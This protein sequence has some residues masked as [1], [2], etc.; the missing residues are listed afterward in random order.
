MDKDGLYVN[1]YYAGLG[2]PKKYANMREPLFISWE[3]FEVLKFE[4]LRGTPKEAPVKEK[5]PDS[6]DAPS[7]DY[8]DKLPIVTL[9][10]IKF[11][12]DMDRKERRPVSNPRHVFNFEKQASE[13]AR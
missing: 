7:K 4:A 8:L 5:L 12:I 9:N 6:I 10:G 13:D 11:Y 1:G 2:S 3:D